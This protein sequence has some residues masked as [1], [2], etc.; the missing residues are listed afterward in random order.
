M[1]LFAISTLLLLLELAFIRWFP[2]HV[3]FLTFFTNVVL[4]ASYLGMSLGC[5][6]HRLERNWLRSTPLLLLA[7]L[8]AGAFMEA[9]RM[10]LEQVVDFGSR[11]SPQLVF[12]GTEYRVPDLARFA[13]PV[14]WIAGFVFLL[15]ALVMIGPGQVLG[16]SLAAIPNS[17]QA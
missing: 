9:L 8:A 1:D 7:S 2:A 5:L 6:A 11:S 4:L 17:L 3:L 10:K 13:I 12:F 15:V 14:E 16:R